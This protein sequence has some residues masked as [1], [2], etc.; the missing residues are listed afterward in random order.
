[1]RPT[2]SGLVPGLR[3]LFV[4]HAGQLGVAQHGRR[5]VSAG[6]SYAWARSQGS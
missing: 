4:H 3:G 2:P 1:M 6:R 5:I